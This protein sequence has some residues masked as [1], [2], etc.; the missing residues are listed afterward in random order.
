MYLGW[1]MKKRGGIMMAAKS[2]DGAFHYGYKKS[3]CTHTVGCNLDISTLPL[4]TP[5]DSLWDGE[6]TL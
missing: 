1:W 6:C 3:Q 5:L 2:I 4:P